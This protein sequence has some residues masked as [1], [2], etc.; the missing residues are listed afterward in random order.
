LVIPAIDLDAPILPVRYEKV[1]VDGEQFTQLLAPNSK[2]VGWH[3]ASAYLGEAG[4]TIL[5]GHHNIHGE[6]FRRL[7]DLEVG[8]RITIFAGDKGYDYVVGTKVILPEM[9][10]PLEA[11]LENARWIQP[12]RDERITLVTCWPYESNTHRVIVVAVPVTAGGAG[13]VPANHPELLAE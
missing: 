5:N 11:R 12:S 4:N 2:S 10:E 9:F 8:D 1:E 13:S 3:Y 6:V 7:V